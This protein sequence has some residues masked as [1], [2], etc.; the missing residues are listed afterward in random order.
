MET[1][2]KIHGS[3][4]ELAEFC[5]LH[6]LTEAED[7]VRYLGLPL[8]EEGEEGAETLDTSAKD[9][10]DFYD[11]SLEMVEDFYESYDTRQ[12]ME[13]QALEP[14][15]QLVAEVIGPLSKYGPAIWSATEPYLTQKTNDCPRRLK[16]Q[17]RRDRERLVL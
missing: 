2:L 13:E 11:R 1:K 4:R 6:R 17:D 16:Y 8:K 10:R 7:Y 12:E 15:K 9:V 14:N 3:L 5:G